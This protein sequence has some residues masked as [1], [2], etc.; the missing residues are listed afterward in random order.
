MAKNDTIFWVIGIAI[1]VFL[2]LPNI[3]LSQKEN[4]IGLT[5][6][7]YDSE[8]NKVVPRYEIP[9]KNPSLFAIFNPPVSNIYNP[10][11]R[12]SDGTTCGFRTYFPIY[13]G[14]GLGFCG[15]TTNYIAGIVFPTTG[16]PRYGMV[17]STDFC[18]GY[19]SAPIGKTTIFGVYGAGLCSSG[20]DGISVWNEI[21]SGGSGGAT[22]TWTSS[23][24][25]LCKRFVNEASS[26][27]NAIENNRPFSIKVLPY[28][29][30]DS[31]FTINSASLTLNY[32]VGSIDL[33]VTAS[34]TGALP[35]ENIRISGVSPNIPAGAFA[36]VSHNLSSG[37]SVSWNSSKIGVESSWAETNQ[38]FLVNVTGYNTY[39]KQ[40]ETRTASVTVPF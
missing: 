22:H 31:I 38:V 10:S 21:F 16:I 35:Y 19:S 25:S 30:G 34:N 18:V 23:S 37:S 27:E 1:F 14:K 29:S 9:I 7:Y 24:G 39:T 28:N 8:G 13:I 20:C 15:Y 26:I 40:T 5:V 36:E 11:R 6:N 4:D 2:I 12:E 33:I 17:T 32:D 3:N